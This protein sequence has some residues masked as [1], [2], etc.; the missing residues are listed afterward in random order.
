MNPAMINK[1]KKMQK[2]MLDAQKKLEQSIFTGT[3]G[4]GMVKVEATGD[5]RIVNIEIDEEEVSSEL[6][7]LINNIHDKWDE[8]YKKLAFYI[9]HDELE[10]VETNFTAGKSFIESKKYTDAM[11]ELEK[12]SFVLTHIKEKYLFSLENIF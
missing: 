5:K 3:A 10:K 6:N 1:L 11:S 8:M 12:T 7:N 4:G 2:E 9:E